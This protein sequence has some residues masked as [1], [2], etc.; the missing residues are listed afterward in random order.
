MPDFSVGTVGTKMSMIPPSNG[1]KAGGEI[2][3]DRSE[4]RNAKSVNLL[5]IGC[6]TDEFLA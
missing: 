6:T 5:D 2:H 3:D 1:C 4:S